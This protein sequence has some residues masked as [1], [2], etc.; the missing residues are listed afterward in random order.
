MKIQV[1]F[2]T[3]IRKH[4]EILT[5]YIERQDLTESLSSVSHLWE[6]LSKFTFFAF[7]SLYFH[8]WICIK[9]CG[10]SG[11]GTY[12]SKKNM[13]RQFNYILIGKMDNSLWDWQT[14]SAESFLTCRDLAFKWILK[15]DVMITFDSLKSQLHSCGL[16]TSNDSNVSMHEV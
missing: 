16:R 11:I 15:F 7:H 13:L 4:K 6:C 8:S 9:S 3:V 2:S 5:L 1:L 14:Q 10:L 12:K